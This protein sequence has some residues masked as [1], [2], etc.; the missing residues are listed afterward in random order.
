MKIT[1]ANKNDLGDIVTL[2]KLFHL[3]V[4]DFR[5]DTQK[6]VLEEIEQQNYFV[7]RE[8]DNVVGAI[9]IK[10][11]GSIAY[12]E[13]IAIKTDKH[14]SGL[15]KKLIQF[16]KEYSISKEKKELKVESFE[17]YGL[18]DFY[19]RVGFRL[20]KGRE[21]FHGKPYMVFSMKL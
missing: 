12:I 13:T 14:R 7:L 16:A 18:K 15:G 17:D 9:C 20:E 21:Y 11:E 4:P 1:K 6:W 5:W 8:N 3:D 2:N 10:F 19:K